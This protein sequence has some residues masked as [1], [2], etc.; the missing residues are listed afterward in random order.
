VARGLILRLAA[1][2]GVGL[3]VGGAIVVVMRLSSE[4]AGPAMQEAVAVRAWL[5]APT[6]LFG[7]PLRADVHVLVDR[8]R[9]DPEGVRLVGGFGPFRLRSRT[10][11]RTDSGTTTS[12]RYRLELLCLERACLPK[13]GEPAP[14]RFDRGFVLWGANRRQALD[15]GGV[16]VASRLSAADR[17]RPALRLADEPPPDATFSASPTGTAALLFGGAALLVLAGL[18][19]LGLEVR[20]VLRRRRERDPFAGLSPLARAL[21]LLERARTPAERRTALDRLAREV[22]D[23][24]LAEEVRQLA[25]SEPAPDAPHAASVA[26]R[27]A[28]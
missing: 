17:V 27:A 7:D 1:A 23:D 12:L 14:V 22:G 8:T 10:V 28:R 13:Q 4:P 5:S 6:V 24:E 18:V 15:W 16:E 19:L 25:W 20:R 9:V 26:A 11:T 2:I 21:A 3:V